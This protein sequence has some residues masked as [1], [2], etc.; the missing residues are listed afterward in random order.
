MSEDQSPNAAQPERIYAGLAGGGSGT[1]L[2]AIATQLSID[3]NLRNLLIYAAPWVA[4]IFGAIAVYIQVRL[5][6]YLKDR[7]AK[8]ML[9]RLR[10]R[11]Q[12][13]DLTDEEK[14]R[15]RQKLVEA[16]EHLAE[17]DLQVI[18]LLEGRPSTADSQTR[19]LE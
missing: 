16:T 4:V 14:A 7:I 5:D 1:G 18:K 15:L 10:A 3:P 17:Q 6:Q 11:L 8:R 2:V 12:D 9:R 13:P 19:L